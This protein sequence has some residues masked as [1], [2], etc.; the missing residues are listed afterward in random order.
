MTH[1]DPKYI[2]T[3]PY[4]I[5]LHYIL[6]SRIRLTNAGD[7]NTITFCFDKLSSYNQCYNLIDALKN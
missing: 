4:D 3:L 5:E 1:P 7:K 6:L 2:I